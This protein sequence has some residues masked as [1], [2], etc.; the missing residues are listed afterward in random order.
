MPCSGC[1]RRRKKRTLTMAV[2]QAPPPNDLILAQVI[3]G[4][5]GDHTI[6]GSATRTRYGQRKDGDVLYVSAADVAMSP[7]TF[8]Q[9]TQD[10]SNVEKESSEPPPPPPQKPIDFTELWGINEERAEKLIEIGARTLSD[11]FQLG[12]KRLSEF[13]PEQT[14]KG[15][16]SRLNERTDI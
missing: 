14:A 5:R 7:R 10:P 6:V 8:K 1:G 11:V 13:M 3:D 9:V 12:V 4:N 16:I 2:Q 15:V